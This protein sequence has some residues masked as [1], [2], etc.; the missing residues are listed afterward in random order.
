MRSF[1]ALKTSIIFFLVWGRGGV[2][3]RLA[4]TLIPAEW[5]GHCKLFAQRVA[6]FEAMQP[7]ICSKDFLSA[8][9]HGEI[10]E[11]DS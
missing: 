4:S 1:L 6:E 11:L 2:T 8:R 3:P 5:C 10:R 9:F 7:V